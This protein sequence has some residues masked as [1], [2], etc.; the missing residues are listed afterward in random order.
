MEKWGRNTNQ[1]AG[2]YTFT[3]TDNAGCTTDTTLTLTAP[4]GPKLAGTLTIT[5]PTCGNSNG[6]ASGWTISGGAA[7]ITAAWKNGGTTISNTTSFSGQPGGTYTL[8]VTDN[9]GCSVDSTITLTNVPGPQFVTTG[10]VITGPTCSLPNGGSITGLQ[11]SD[12]TPDSS[13]VW[14]NSS[15][16]TVSSVF[17][18]TSQPGGTYTFTFIDKSGCEID[19]PFTL[20]TPAGLVVNGTLKITEPTCGASNGAVSGWNI[21]GGTQP[22]TYVWKSNGTTITS[23]TTSFMGQSSGT[24]NLTV[25]DVNSCSVDTSVSLSNAGGPQLSGTLKISDPTCGRTN[26]SVSGWVV[27]GGTSPY[28]YVWTIN[29]DT[30]VSDTTSFTNQGGGTYN[31]VVTDG[32]GCMKDSVV[33][34]TNI[35]GPQLSGN[36][37]ITQPT[38]GKSNGSVTGW[39]AT[40]G[41]PPYT[42][43]WTKNGTSVSD[44]FGFVNQP[45]GNYTFVVMDSNGCSTADST[46][47]LVAPGSPVLDTTGLAVTE[48]TCDASN[49]SVSGLT[50]SGGS[51]PYAEVWTNSSSMTISDTFTFSNQPSGKYYFT[52][53]DNAGCIAS[54]T[55][56]LAALNAPG[57]LTNNLEITN[58]SCGNANGSILGLQVSGGATPYASEVWTDSATAGIVST[59]LSLD[60]QP[61]GTFIFTVTDN[62]GCH[63]DT[64]ITLVATGAATPPLIAITNGKDSICSSGDT[65]QIC[66]SNSNLYVAYLWSNNGTASCIATNIP[67]QCYVTGTDT[68]GCKA[69]SNVL[70]IGVKQSPSISTSQ[71][72]DTLECYDILSCQWFYNG[73]AI[74]APQGTDSIYIA[75][76]KGEYT[77]LITGANGCTALSSQILDTV[78]AGINNISALVQFDIFPNPATEGVLELKN[79][80]QLIGLQYRIFDVTGKLVYSSIIR[81][82]QNEINIATFSNGV[83]LLKVGDVMKQFVK[84]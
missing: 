71:S 10:V 69:I 38:C 32:T 35:T 3:L 43:S 47:T 37:T 2:T 83:Y 23:D 19:T 42:E 44:S 84:Q 36:L 51:L 16:T 82:E 31:L 61:G 60:S 49:G 68:N 46:I 73:V 34:L 55:L 66:V 24:Y 28:N 13:T 72:G 30:I 11:V 59:T 4:V 15:G 63:V 12:A 20:N 25:T 77:V 27:T 62:S 40:G 14:T 50:A 18:L 22:Y 54:Y 70:N 65:A 64:S 39:N 52:L 78:I 29:G 56:T 9:A 81:N 5:E 57:F 45:A 48:P 80:A 7:P 67:G 58:P 79:P 26:G 21:T 41:T 76:A 17:D 6:G 33:T 75:T 8:T 74:P 1:P 53:T